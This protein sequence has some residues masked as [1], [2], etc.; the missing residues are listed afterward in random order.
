YLQAKDARAARK[1]KDLEARDLILKAFNRR[2][3]KKGSRSIKMTLEHDFQCIMSRKKIQRI[4]RKYE[5][6]C[7]HRRPNPYKQMAKA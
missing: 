6:V 3:Y 7:P 2:G 5:I 4:M 1:Q